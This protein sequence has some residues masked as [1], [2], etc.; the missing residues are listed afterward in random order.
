MRYSFLRKFCPARPSLV[1]AI[2]ARGDV[3]RSFSG[4]VHVK[5][6]LHNIKD[7][8]EIAA[9]PIGFNR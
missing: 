4:Y 7:K 6:R 1:E 9:E 5:L 8:R 3:V 2:L